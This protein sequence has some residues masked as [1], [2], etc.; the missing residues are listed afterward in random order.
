M[1]AAPLVVGTG[2]L[3]LPSAL[4]EALPPAHS[5]LAASPPRR[6]KLGAPCPG[7]GWGVVAGLGVG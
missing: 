5:P 1:L 7:E 6:L 3:G 4:P 2:D